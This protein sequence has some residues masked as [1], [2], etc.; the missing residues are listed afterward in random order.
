MT[1]T[2]DNNE[3]TEDYV[4]LYNNAIL[5]ATLMYDSG[6]DWKVEAEGG[7]TS[8]TA[9]VTVAANTKYIKLRFKEGTGANAEIEFWASSN[10]TSW[11]DNLSVSDG[12]SEAQV[13]K[14]LFLNNHDNEIV[15]IDNFMEHSADIT[16]AR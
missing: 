1:R 3:N 9:T 14:V 5:L 11:G 15:R 2:N 10:G 12:T 7:S 6:N 13:N 4:E 8:G 16:D